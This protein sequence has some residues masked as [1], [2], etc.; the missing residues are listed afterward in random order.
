MLRLRPYL[1]TDA[2]R[3]VS[4][5]GDEAA[6]YRWTAGVAGPYPPTRE[7]PGRLSQLMRFTLLD[8]EAPAGFFTLRCPGESPDEVRF[9]FVIVD[10]QKRSRGYGREMLRLGLAFAKDIYRA[11][12]ASLGV[13]VNNE[14]ARR[15]Y[16]AA[17][18]TETGEEEEYPVM[19]GTWKC[20]MME[21]PLA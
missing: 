7:M 4:W 17:G 12:K 6:F 14:P 10:P 20:R 16:L 13:F 2:E 8:G 11:K 15:C 19:G 5:C 21:L 18:F 3:V 1:D 9:G